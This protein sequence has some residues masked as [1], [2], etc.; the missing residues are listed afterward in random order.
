M[1]ARYHCLMAV[2]TAADAPSGMHRQHRRA[3]K[4]R[5]QR[6]KTRHRKS[7]IASTRTAE[8]A[9]VFRNTACPTCGDSDVAMCRP[10]E[11]EAE[12]RRV[13][14]GQCC[15]CGAP[16]RAQMRPAT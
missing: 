16:I 2:T 1:A 10:V 6:M 15:H 7:A 5:L 13:L 8:P 11:H 12:G 9:W 4:C 3:E 14:E